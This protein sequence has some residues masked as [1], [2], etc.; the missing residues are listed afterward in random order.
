MKHAE[1]TDILLQ[2]TRVRMNEIKTGLLQINDPKGYQVFET[3]AAKTYG[4]SINWPSINAAN[5]AAFRV[6]GNKLDRMYVR[7]IKHPIGVKLEHNNMPEECRIILQLYSGG[8]LKVQHN[9]LTT[10]NKGNPFLNCRS[11][12]SKADMAAYLFRYI[13]FTRLA[14]SIKRV[15]RGYLTRRYIAMHGPAVYNRALCINEEDCVTMDPLSSLSVHQFFSYADGDKIYG[16]DVNSFYGIIG[17]HGRANH[18]KEAINP[19]TRAPI[20]SSTINVVHKMVQ[21]G[22]KILKTAINISV[23]QFDSGQTFE[24][25]ALMLFQAINSLGFHASHEWLLALT[26]GELLAMWSCLQE[27]WHVRIG[28]SCDVRRAIYPPRGKLNEGLTVT[29]RMSGETIRTVLVTI[30]SRLVFSGINEEARHLGAF[31]VLGALTIVSPAAARSIPWL[32]E[33]FA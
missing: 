32:A 23:S 8:D 21:I 18:A 5:A 22:T 2:K 9:A 15:Y 13:W 30:M 25:R 16:F 29:N 28:I 14:T 6:M 26:R 7:T 27:I 20:G 1:Y 3:W 33:S 10:T 24:M 31:Y 12:K 19:Y 11:K 17:K 4:L